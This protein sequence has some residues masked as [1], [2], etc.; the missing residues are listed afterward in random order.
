MAQP[1]HPTVEPS[2]PVDNF[3]SPANF[4]FYSCQPYEPLDRHDQ[5]IR[6][7]AVK[8]DASGR[9][10]CTLRESVPLAEADNT[11]TAIFYCAGD[12]KKTQSIQVNGLR[13]NAF[14]NLALA[15]EYTYNYR[16]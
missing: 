9:F 14:A 3:Y 16:V 12:P 7:L 4:D 5:A 6:L 13:F 11:Y 15:I 2:V 8:K 1:N 10:E